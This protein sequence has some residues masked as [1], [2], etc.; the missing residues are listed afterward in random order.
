MS[1]QLDRTESNPLNTIAKFIDSRKDQI[2]KV[3][4]AGMDIERIT[5]IAIAAVSR[6]PQ[7]MKCSP[8]SIYAAI[9][10]GVQLGLEPGSP[11]GE[12]YLVP[13]WNKNT[14]GYEATFIPGYQ[15]L[16][17]LARRSG[18]VLKIYARIV[19]SN[20]KFN[21]RLGLHEELEHI[22]CLDGDRGDPR[23]VYAVAHIRDAEPQF[24]ILTMGDIERT[25]AKSGSRNRNGELTGP[26]VTDTEAMMLKTAIKRVIKFI[27]KETSKDGGKFA[28]AVEVD[29]GADLEPV[30]DV[31][32]DGGHALPESTG[33]EPAPSASARA[34]REKAAVRRQGA[35]DEAEHADEHEGN[36]ESESPASGE[37]RA[38]VE[39]PAERR[40]TAKPSPATEAADHEA[41]LIRDAIDDADDEDTLRT[42]QDRLEK[43]TPRLPLAVRNELND[44]IKKAAKQIGVSL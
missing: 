5:K 14:R 36:D 1:T 35:S 32:P 38:P 33:A 43:A 8:Q 39:P 4:A 20:D 24:E 13:F 11:L 40:A 34:Q 10:T 16:I 12:G 27:P 2:K 17:T 29:D 19:Y 6:S 3:M 23:F 25:K 15:G 30:L 21:V 9:H 22:P 7:L 26:W 37:V 42:A 44:A 28:R 18:V 41:G 31:T